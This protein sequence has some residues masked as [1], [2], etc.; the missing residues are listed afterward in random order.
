MGNNKL[1]DR[2][3]SHQDEVNNGV[4]TVDIKGGSSHKN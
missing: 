3:N 1:Q 2:R 4:E